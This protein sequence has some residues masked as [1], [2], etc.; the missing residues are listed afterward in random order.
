[1]TAPTGALD[2]R[3]AIITGASRGIGAALVDAYRKHNYAVV[4]NSRT[5]NPAETRVW[6]PLRATLPIRRSPN[7]S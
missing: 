6:S 3:V 4:A 2:Q 5:I 1:M 7:N